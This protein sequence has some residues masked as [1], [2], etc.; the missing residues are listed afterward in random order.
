MSRRKTK[1]KVVPPP[2]TAPVSR[3]KLWWFRLAA[4]LAGPCLLFG[5]L[6][7]GLRLAGFGYPTAFLL[8][9]ANHDTATFIQNDRFGWRFFGPRAARQPAATSIPQVKPPDTIRIV[10]LGESAAYGDPQPRFGLP[11]MLGALLTLRHPGQK[12]EVVNAA[13]TAINSHVIRPLARGCKEAHADAWVIY[14]GNNEV[15]G[16]FGAGTVFGGQAIP[17]PLIRAGLALKTTRTGQL[18]DAVLGATH[19]TAAN[20]EWEGMK[21]FIN[22][23]LAASD[24]RLEAVYSNFAHNLNDIIAAG[25]NSGAKIVLST[26]GVNLADCAPFAS[27]HGS[28]LTAAQ[29]GDWQHLFAAGTNSQAS[30][31][32]QPAAADYE[33]AEQM[34]PDYADL[35]FRRGQCLLALHDAVAAQKEFLAAR[36]LDALRF[37][38]DSRLNEIIRSRVGNDVTL[39]DGEA[40]L[41]DA[42]P[43]GIP[44]AKMFY[45]HVH[46]TFEGNY[47]LARAIAAKVEAALG[48]ASDGS[49]PD[50]AACEQRLGHTPRDTQLA[51][52]IL[53]ARMAD[54]PFTFQSNHQDQMRRL[55]EMARALPP[56]DSTASLQGAQS[57]AEAALKQ[58]PD[59]AELWEQLGEIKAREGDYP[60]GAAAIQKALALVPSEGPE[61]WLLYGT[62]LAQEEKYPEAIAAFKQVSPFYSRADWAGFNLALCL[63]KLGQR[64]EAVLQFKQ[65]LT[66]KP[67]YGIG[68]LAYGQLLEQMGRTAEAAQCYSTALT[69]HFT[70]AD[71]LVRLA[72]FCA[73]RQW[74]GLAV[75]NYT[76]AIALS[77][78]DPALRFEA[79]KALAAFD[80]HD[81]AARQYA[82]AIE[83]APEKIQP[84]LELGFE[85]GRLGDTA[86]AEQEFRQVLK[87]D[88]NSVEAHL[89]LGVALYQ[90]KKLDEALQQFD[91]V[92]QLDP[93]NATAL[94]FIQVLRARAH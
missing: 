56:A 54:A 23:K 46:L 29:I 42:S 37:R 7:A 90:G 30:G 38:C 71:D 92:L 43:D 87:L 86:S 41:A 11:R 32:F 80:R 17:L 94:R 82:A 2:A 25:R 3:R 52:S 91:T 36:D 28:Q 77:P 76:A 15:V 69:N 84:H 65:L 9:S 44:G 39:A 78:S 89:A 48:L 1:R 63:E 40:V 85:L 58:S 24:P 45:E 21:M 8:K 4:V 88:P 68:W 73:S 22:Y 12:F 74:L 75:T 34:D 16:P 93:G 10:V 35:R 51:L 67:D 13:M 57:A 53:S 60:G 18:L 31:D 19:K 50:M 59:D 27:L 6:E 20:G 62:L 72:R 79:G 33:L 55:T 83:L 14:M 49:W 70:Q 26:V 66:L 5:L 64:D 81:E 47:V 61:C